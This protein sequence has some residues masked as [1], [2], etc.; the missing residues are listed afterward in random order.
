MHNVRVAL[1][2]IL[3]Q[4]NTSI[5]TIKSSSAKWVGFG[6]LGTSGRAGHNPRHGYCEFQAD[7]LYSG[8]ILQ[9]HA[10]SRQTPGMQPICCLFLEF[11]HA[12]HACSA[13][14]LRGAL[15]CLFFYDFLLTYTWPKSCSFATSVL[16][17][18]VKIFR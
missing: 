11:L 5:T 17:E 16:N 8:S 6:R 2:L 10:F 14:P 9:N 3:N 18:F 13:R 1:E 12:G 4:T 15:L 7:M